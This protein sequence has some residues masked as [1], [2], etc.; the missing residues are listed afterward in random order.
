[1]EPPKI[2]MCGKRYVVNSLT[3]VGTDPNA[4]CPT[5]IGKRLAPLSPRV[6]KR[7][8]KA[9]PDL[10]AK[11]QKLKSAEAD[12]SGSDIFGGMFAWGTET[13]STSARSE[14]ART[15]SDADLGAVRPLL[16]P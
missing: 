2:G 14:P 5:L 16:S 11:G 1:R 10:E 9:D 3:P 15:S 12:S 6:A 4:A 7:L 13:K 8:V